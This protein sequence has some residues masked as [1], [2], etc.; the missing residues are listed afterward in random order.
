MTV[1]HWNPKR[2]R[3]FIACIAQ[4][5]GRKEPDFSIEDRLDP[6]LVETLQ[7]RGVPPGQITHLQDQAA[8]TENLREKFI[9]CLRA[10]QPGVL[11]A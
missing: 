7:K 6:A 4:F 11:A 9:Q 10:S 2:T 8:T 1:S 5:K 3:A